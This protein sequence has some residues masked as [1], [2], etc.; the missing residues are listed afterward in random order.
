MSLT[1]PS[2]PACIAFVDRYFIV[3]L[4]VVHKGGH[5]LVDVHD[6][7]DVNPRGVLVFV[8]VVGGAVTRCPRSLLCI[9]TAIPHR[10]S[11]SFCMLKCS[12]FVFVHD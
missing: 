10:Y 6:E 5:C 2:I 3:W 4:S 7:N 8:Y 12:A 1:R 9:L 11:F